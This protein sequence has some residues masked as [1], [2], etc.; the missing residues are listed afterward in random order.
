MEETACFAGLE[1]YFNSNSHKYFGFP[2]NDHEEKV[3]RQY[4]ES[5]KTLFEFAP[6]MEDIDWKKGMIYFDLSVTPGHMIFAICSCIR[7]T[8]EHPSLIKDTW[9]T[10]N[11]KSKFDLT[12]HE[13]FIFAHYLNQE[14][15]NTNHTLYPPFE[16]GI[17]SQVKFT[18]PNYR[19]CS[20][21]GKKDAIPDKKYN[22]P[23]SEYPYFRSISLFR[24]YTSPN[25]V[26]A[27]VWERPPKNQEFFEYL[28]ERKNPNHNWKGKTWIHGKDD[29]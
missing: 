4:V 13:K 23:F 25:V 24:S 27:D 20:N 21:Y 6:Y 10:L 11:D 28:F 14:R 3:V 29:A 19:A 9:K 26:Q 12:D 1:S 18:K 16:S 8:L 17:E 22:E 5:V 15:T 7:N 2:I